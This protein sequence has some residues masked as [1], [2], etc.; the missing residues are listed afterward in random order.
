MA[1]ILLFARHAS[2]SRKPKTAGSAHKPRFVS[3]LET[4]RKLS[5]G[6]PPRDRQLLTADKPTPINSAT[7]RVPPKASMTSSTELSMPD[8]SSR[9]VIL[10][11]VHDGCMDGDENI[12]S[13]NKMDPAD[14]IARR[15]D[16]FLKVQAMPPD[17]LTVAEIAEWFG[18]TE[19]AIS[20]YRRAIR[21]LNIEFADALC[22]KFQ[23]TLDFLYR[24]DPR[25]IKASLRKK[26]REIEELEAQKIIRIGGKNGLK[27]KVSRTV[28]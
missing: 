16:L 1:V 10:S 22:D 9:S 28:R 3:S 15:L 8:D 19:P 6:I 7:A 21:P 27:T 20:N 17:R 4:I 2:T 24:G 25:G 5:D 12:N 18:L 23:L 11:R 14:Q 13:N 26:M